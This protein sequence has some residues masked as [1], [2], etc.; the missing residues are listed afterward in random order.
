MIQSCGYLKSEFS[1]KGLFFSYGKWANLIKVIFF[2]KKFGFDVD[3][4]FM[5][6]AVMFFRI[7]I[8]LT[9]S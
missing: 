7:I 6:L 9:Q 5:Q 2:R 8:K 3:S 4:L 1:K